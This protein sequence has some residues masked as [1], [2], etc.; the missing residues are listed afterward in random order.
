MNL[1]QVFFDQHD[2]DGRPIDFRTPTSKEEVLNNRLGKILHAHN[3][4]VAVVNENKNNIAAINTTV[5]N[6]TT[7]LKMRLDYLE[8]ITERQSQMLELCFLVISGQMNTNDVN[9]I[10]KM[11]ASP[12]EENHHV[13]SQIIK[14]KFEELGVATLIDHGFNLDESEENN[15]SITD[16]RF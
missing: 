6:E 12:D 10:H 11:Q 14:S 9:R 7:L 5:T 16:C 2:D 3:Q 1:D 8:G 4:M 13:A 15:D